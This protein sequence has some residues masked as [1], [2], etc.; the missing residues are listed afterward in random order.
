MFET[1]NLGLAGFVNRVH[2]RCAFREPSPGLPGIMFKSST[3]IGLD[4]MVAPQQAGQRIRELP[5]HRATQGPPSHA[6]RG[7]TFDGVGIDHGDAPALGAQQH[8]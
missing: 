7:A 8:L 5:A 6:L 4:I 2:S 3:S 1:P